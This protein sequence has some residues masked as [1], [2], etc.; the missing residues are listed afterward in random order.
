MS[1]KARTS[2]QKTAGQSRLFVVVA[3]AVCL[4][5]LPLRL[6]CTDCGWTAM[7][8]AMAK[9][10][11]DG[12]GGSG[13]SDDSGSDN[14]GSGGGGSSGSGSGKSGSGDDDGGKDHGRR[15]GPDDATEDADDDDRGPANS[16]GRSV[17]AFMGLL[18]GR[19]KVAAVRRGRDSLEIQFADGWRERIDKGQFTLI[20]HKNR[21]VVR[22]PAT[23][24]DMRRLRE[25]GKPSR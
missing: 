10:G 16:S 21:V 5:S 24:M 8:S 19:G 18:N 11:N 7:Q 12:S 9:D 23:G 15:G 1:R 3:L 6:V 25:A 14:S 2:L 20:D 22:R 17:R 4:S 13:G